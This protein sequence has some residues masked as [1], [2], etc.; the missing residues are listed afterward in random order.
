LA[1]AGSNEVIG[2]VVVVVVVLVVRL[3]LRTLVVRQR[4]AFA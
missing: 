4:G 3:R 2:V 1:W